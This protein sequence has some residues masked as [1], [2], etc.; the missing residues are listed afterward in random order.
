MI[1]EHVPAPAFAAAD[2][3]GKQHAL[4]DYRGQW[5]ILY[6]Y[7]KDDT[8]GCTK[9]ACGF[10]DTFAELSRYAQVFGISSDSPASHQKFM[11]KYQLPFL[12]LSDADGSIRESF[13][14]D[15]L[16][17]PK[18]VTFLIDPQGTIARIY[19]DIDVGHHAEQ[20]LID[21][22]HLAA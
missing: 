16:L 20:I 1:Q 19:S 6:F 21:L 5:V 14:A 17:F 10:R 4:T 15:G 9:E 3:H 22:Q 13:G 11:Q 2:Q 12:L 8:P 7:P 18:R